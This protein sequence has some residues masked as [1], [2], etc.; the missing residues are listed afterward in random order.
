V[1]LSLYATFYNKLSLRPSYLQACGATSHKMW[2][3]TML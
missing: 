3:I 1:E 2:Y